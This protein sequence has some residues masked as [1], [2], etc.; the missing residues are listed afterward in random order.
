[1]FYPAILRDIMLREYSSM[2]TPNQLRHFLKLS[3]SDGNSFGINFNIVTLFYAD[4][5]FDNN[6]FN[7]QT[8]VKVLEK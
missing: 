7:Q 4:T 5:F 2:L 3:P 8:I 1:M 6:F